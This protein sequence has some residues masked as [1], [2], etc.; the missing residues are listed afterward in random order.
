MKK[1]KWWFTGLAVAII[2]A[3]TQIGHGGLTP[4][5][6]V[7]QWTAPSDDADPGKALLYDMRY[8][9]D[10]MDLINDWWN[11]AE[12]FG[13]PLPADSDVVELFP[14]T[15]QLRVGKTYYVSII[16]ADTIQQWRID[17]LLA[18]GTAIDSLRATDS[19]DIYA[20]NWSNPVV[21]HAIRVHDRR[22][23]RDITDLRTQ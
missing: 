5:D 11:Q 16:A 2:G 19:L 12:V 22:P 6:K 17:T 13:L 9:R 4:V 1:I 3:L 23:P 20:R 14:V 7:F 8:A 21:F 10:S 18:Q 15:L